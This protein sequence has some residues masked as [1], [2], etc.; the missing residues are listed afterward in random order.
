MRMTPATDKAGVM[1]GVSGN[2]VPSSLAAKS[3]VMFV[4]ADPVAEG[5]TD[6]VKVDGFW[7][8]AGFV[9]V[10]RVAEG[11]AEASVCVDWPFCV[12]LAVKLFEGTGEE[13]ETWPEE[14]L[15]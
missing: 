11:S 2:V 4:L 3:A 10:A 12:E 14:L 13:A 8:E 7:L 9:E 1:A 15:S 6:V 5:R